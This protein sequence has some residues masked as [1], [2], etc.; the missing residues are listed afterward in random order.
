MNLE[1]I[2]LVKISDSSYKI[3]QLIN[4]QR[5]N[6]KLEFNE[7]SSPFGLEKFFNV[8]YINWEIDSTSLITLKQL[9]L[10][11]K[12]LV[13]TSNDKYKSWSWTTN[14]KEKKDFAP[15]LKTRVL[16]KKKKFCVNSDSSLFEI[17]Y[18]SKLNI[19][20][21]LD[22]IWFNDKNKTFGLLWVCQSIKSS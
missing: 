6:L 17:N 22:S 2:D 10:E 14:I 3:Y 18:K 4:S 11:F 1:N 7:I 21:T 16:E 15:L 20:I 5:T 13:L 12:D 19:E 8:Y 9:E